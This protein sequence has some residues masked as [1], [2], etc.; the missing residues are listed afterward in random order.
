MPYSS[1]RPSPSPRPTTSISPR[2]CSD[3]SIAPAADAAD[4]LDLR[5]ADRLAVRDDRE[6]LERRRRKPLRARRELRAL[7]RFGVLGARQDLPS[8]A[9]L[10]QLDAVPV[11]VVV[12]AQLVEGDSSVVSPSSA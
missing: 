5:A 8:A 4:L 11:V 2:S 6:R 7:D 12:L 9:D 3:L 10:D 1:G